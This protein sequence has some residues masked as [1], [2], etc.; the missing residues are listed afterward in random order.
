METKRGYVGCLLLYHELVIFIIT[1]KAN[2]RG[3]L[4]RIA[5]KPSI[6]TE[7][8]NKNK[9]HKCASR[10]GFSLKLLDGKNQK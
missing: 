2:R 10:K 5:K 3:K 4:I 8:K 1:I 7:V 6:S 9:T